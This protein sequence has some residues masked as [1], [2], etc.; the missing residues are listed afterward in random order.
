VFAEFW[1]VE[2]LAPLLE[3]AAAEEWHPWLVGCQFVVV[4]AVGAF[5]AAVLLLFSLSLDHYFGLIMMSVL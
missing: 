2:E 4:V 5:P 1:Y 3:W